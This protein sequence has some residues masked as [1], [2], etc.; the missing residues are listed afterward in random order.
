[1]N[2]WYSVWVMFFI[3]LS[4]E[5][6]EAG[7][8]TISIPLTHKKCL[9]DLNCSKIITAHFMY[10]KV[11]MTYFISCNLKNTEHITLKRNGDACVRKNL[12]WGI[13]NCHCLYCE[14]SIIKVQK[15]KY[16]LYYFL[17]PVFWCIFLLYFHF[18]FFPDIFFQRLLV[19]L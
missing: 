16:L 6:S 1:M 18:R 17:I 13:I 5:E 11:P 7:W 9:E 3:L 8:E 2:T 14:L 15:A 4:Q 12:K 10:N 19:C